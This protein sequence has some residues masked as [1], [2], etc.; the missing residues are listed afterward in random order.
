MWSSD[1]T[2]LARSSADESTTLWL[3]LTVT[4]SSL[5]VLTR[6]T[7]FEGIFFST[8]V[9]DDG[10]LHRSAHR[11]IHQATFF[12]IG[13]LL[14]IEVRF[15][16]VRSNVSHHSLEQFSI[17]AVSNEIFVRPIRHCL[18]ECPSLVIDKASQVFGEYNSR[19]VHA[20]IARI[21]PV[22]ERNVT[23]RAF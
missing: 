17:D 16:A 10:F 23:H 4:L 22:P 2:G 15:V 7:R 11:P 12:V 21:P 5:R 20:A 6:R 18:G 9:D 8:P 19:S 1:R 3:R 14:L 13:N